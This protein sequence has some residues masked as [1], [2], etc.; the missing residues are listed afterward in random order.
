MPFK[1]A[2]ASGKGGTGKTTV[3]VNLYWNLVQTRDKATLLVD[4]DVEEPNDIL[5]FPGA[6]I[7]FREDITQPVPEIDPDLCTYCRKCVRYCQF[8]AITVIPPV[9]FAQVAPDLCHSC[10]ACLYACEDNA[11]VEKPVVIG[12]LTHYSAGDGK[13]LTE[14]RLKVGLALQTPVIRR[15]KNIHDDS[16]A[17]VIYDS[18]PGTSCPV[19]AVISDA[20]YV[21]LV[22]EPTP[23]GLHDLKI[24]VDVVRQVD[25]PFGVVI[26]K[27]GLGNEEVYD[28]LE[29]ENIP[30]LTQIPFRKDYARQY[31]ES[32]ILS[33]DNKEYRVYYQEIMDKI[34]DSSRI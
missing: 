4:C 5:F 8:N 15:V 20:D 2:I 26:N 10:G 14:G 23:F 11:I 30:V 7:K 31:S 33:E 22:T 16:A 12:T 9:K 34:F 25:K 6:G 18:P 32:L 3:A 19:V 27:A 17:Y 24:A 29:E 13:G 1:I 21:I 28:F